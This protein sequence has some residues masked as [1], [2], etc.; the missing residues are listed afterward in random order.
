MRLVS[1]PARMLLFALYFLEELFLANLRVARD[2]LRPRIQLTTGIIRFQTQ[3]LS[4]WER[5]HL[6]NAITMTPGTLTLEVDEETG[7]L[8]VHTLYA[9][10][11]DAFLASM[12]RL[13]RLLVRA[14]R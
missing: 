10:D 8:Y 4:D 14:L 6:A 11:R 7:D 5:T 1:R 9:G 2:V 12:Q 3:P 13:E